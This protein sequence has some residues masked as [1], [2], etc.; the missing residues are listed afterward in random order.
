MNKTGWSDVFAAIFLLA[1]VSLLV[2]PA[3]LG[4]SLVQSSGTALTSLVQFA[5]SS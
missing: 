2:R 4:P 1:I 3:S 5:V